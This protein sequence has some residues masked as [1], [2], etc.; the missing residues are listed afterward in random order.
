M[1][2]KKRVGKIFNFQFSIERLNKFQKKAF[3]IFEPSVWWIIAIIVLAIMFGAIF[4]F[5]GKADSALSYAKSLL[6]FGR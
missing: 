1:S 2:F 4:I 5:T 3:S 6:R